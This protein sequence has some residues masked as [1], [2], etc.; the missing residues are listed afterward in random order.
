MGGNV[1]GRVGGKVGGKV[2]GGGVGVSSCVERGSCCSCHSEGFFGRG[3]GVS[4]R[5][6][7][8]VCGRSTHAGVGA[9]ASWV[10]SGMSIHTV[11]LAGAAA[12]VTGGVVVVVIV[13]VVRGST[14]ARGGNW[15]GHATRLLVVSTQAGVGAGA[16]VSAV[17][18]AREEVGGVCEKRSGQIATVG[19]CEDKD[20]SSWFAAMTEAG[21]AEAE[22]LGSPG[23]CWAIEMQPSVAGQ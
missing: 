9:T 10:G 21:K 23:H 18:S 11:L 4:L 5:T 12:A 15:S 19:R 2:G 1:G 13:V 22:R 3:V 16:A 8:A 20:S 7:E 14:R 17:G 6:T